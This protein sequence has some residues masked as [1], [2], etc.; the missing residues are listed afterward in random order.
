[1]RVRCTCVVVAGFLSRRLGPK[2]VISTAV[3]VWI[4]ATLGTA[5]WGTVFSA[6][7]ASRVLIGIAEGFNC[8][9]A[10]C[11]CACWRRRWR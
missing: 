7:Y 11:V 9:S 3:G 10:L 6:L 5:L 2:L 8:A 1:M 4:V